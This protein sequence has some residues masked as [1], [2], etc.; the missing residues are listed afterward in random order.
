MIAT[1]S[2][3]SELLV[4]D[5]R[6][7]FTVDYESV[8]NLPKA[9]KDDL[10]NIRPSKKFQLIVDCVGETEVISHYQSLIEPKNMGSAYATVQGDRESSKYASGG[11][12]GYVFNLKMVG[13]RTAPYG[14]LKYIVISVSTKGNWLKVARGIDFWRS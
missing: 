9:V 11:P 5:R 14:V 8:S 1:Y 7:D 13:R 3:S 10:Q 2:K 4:K 6:A 12:V